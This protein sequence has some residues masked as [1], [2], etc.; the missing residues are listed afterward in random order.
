MFIRRV[1]R[2]EN[3]NIYSIDD[4]I[5]ECL[6]TPIDKKMNIQIY[7]DDENGLEMDSIVV[8]S[9]DMEDGYGSAQDDSDSDDDKNN[10]SLSN[11]LKNDSFRCFSEKINL[12]IHDDATDKYTRKKSK[13]K[14][15]ILTNLKTKHKSLPQTFD[16]VDPPVPVKFINPDITIYRPTKE[17]EVQVPKILG[18]IPVPHIVKSVRRKMVALQLRTIELNPIE[19]H[20]LSQK[21]NFLFQKILPP[22]NLSNKVPPPMIQSIIHV[23]QA[24][25][26]NSGGK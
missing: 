23:N 15:G 4:N 16:N 12:N 17:V 18:K 1:L 6:Q 26:R 5:K 9:G 24:L 14:K 21:N 20:P 13:K 8:G 3:L 11:L 2:D 19:L 10:T 22:T 7:N 25:R